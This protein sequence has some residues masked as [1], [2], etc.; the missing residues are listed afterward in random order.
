MEYW[1]DGSEERNVNF[2]GWPGMHICIQLFWV[3]TVA[4][5]F[6]YMSKYIKQC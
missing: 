5:Y 3:D 4:D 1:K 6:T 2:A